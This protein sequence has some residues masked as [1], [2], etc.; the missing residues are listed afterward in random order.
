LVHVDFVV[1]F[2]ET[3]FGVSVWLFYDSDDDVARLDHDGRSIEVQDELLSLLSA[4]GYPAEWLSKVVF[5]VDSR[6]NV[7]RNYQGSYFHRLR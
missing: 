4:D 5:A 1:A 6:A 7:E 2:V 3:N